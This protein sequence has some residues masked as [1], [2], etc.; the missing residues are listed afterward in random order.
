MK[1][2]MA[3]SWAHRGVDVVHYEVGQDVPDD[4]DLIA[5]A[6]AEGWIEKRETKAKK[7]A[8]ENK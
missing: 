2:K 6:L 3:F 8:P 1:A 4:Q 5:V 7:A